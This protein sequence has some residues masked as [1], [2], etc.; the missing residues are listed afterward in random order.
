MLVGMAV[1]RFE[2]TYQR[3]SLEHHALTLVGTLR[4]AQAT[5]VVERRAYRWAYDPSAATYWLAVNTDT[6]KPEVF[7]RL[8]SRWGRPH[9]L[10]PALHLDTPRTQITF[11]PDG[12]AEAATLKLEGARRERFLVTVDGATGNASA[13]LVRQP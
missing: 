3:I 1:P 12:R 9:V 11:Y 13:Q 10:P 8:P 7:D 6:A 4:Y 2:R 5:A